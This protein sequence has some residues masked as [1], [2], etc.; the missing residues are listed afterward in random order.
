MSKALK[1]IKAS[2]FPAD[3]T[4]PVIATATDDEGAVLGVETL[5]LPVNGDSVTSKEYPVGTTVTF[6]EGE[7]V[8]VDGY[9]F[10]GMEFSPSSIVI[11]ADSTAQVILTNEY[12]PVPPKPEEPKPEKPGPDTELPK[13]GA[14]ILV[15]LIGG[16]VAM[17]AGAWALA[18]S[19]K[20]RA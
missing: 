4:F 18:S 2:D 8:T 14:G 7:H 1:G 11:E 13:T 17:G 15:P 6:E 3:T 10:E 19:R 12:A 9:T 16:A 5:N 20:R